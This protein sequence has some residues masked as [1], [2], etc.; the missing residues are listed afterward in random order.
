[1]TRIETLTWHPVD[2]LPDADTD[3]LLAF[4]D[5][6]GTLLGAWMGEDEGGWVGTDGAPVEGVLYWAE[7]PE[8][9]RA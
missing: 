3:V 9:P 1:M 5:A 8:G 6:A 2:Q 4:G 7:M